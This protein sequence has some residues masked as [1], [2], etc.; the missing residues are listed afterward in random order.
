MITLLL[1]SQPVIFGNEACLCGNKE[2]CVDVLLKLFER[3]IQSGWKD[4]EKRTFII[5]PCF[6]FFLSYTH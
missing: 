2:G 5:V 6:C 1:F 3:F 4:L